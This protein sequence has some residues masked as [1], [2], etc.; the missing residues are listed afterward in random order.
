MKTV[1]ARGQDRSGTTVRVVGTDP[2]SRAPRCMIALPSGFWTPHA[3][4]RARHRKGK[5][6]HFEHRRVRAEEP[7]DFTLGRRFDETACSFDVDPPEVGPRSAYLNV[8]IAS[9]V[10]TSSKLPS[11]GWSPRPATSP[12]ADRSRRP[13]R[14][15]EGRRPGS[16][17]DRRST[18]TVTSD[19]A[20]L[21]SQAVCELLATSP[22]S[23]RPPGS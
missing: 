19:P 23:S 12:R 14:L 17:K 8:S 20:R 13:L 7:F 11:P 15:L 10:S 22:F 1:G 4:S 18:S 9:T 21:A 16:D 3:P 2:E 5:S 6:L